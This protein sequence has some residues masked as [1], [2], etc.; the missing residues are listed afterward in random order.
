[1]IELETDR[2]SLRPVRAD[3]LQA[4]CEL[5]ADTRVMSSVGGT[6]SLEQCRAWLER[7]LA[8]WQDY[9]YGRYSVARGDQFVGLV[10]L[11]R[12]DFDRAMVPG[13]E[14]AWR[15]AFDEWG[16]GYATEAARAAIA[17]GFS[18][19]GL[20]EVIGVTSIDNARSRRVMVRLGMTHSPR[21]TFE[22]PLLPD[23]DPLRTHVLYRLRASVA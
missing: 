19:V 17:H 6:L 1:M 23:G 18:S 11:S 8:H 13:I 7:Q 14:I 5:S 3:D 20:H 16:H 21:E 22:H 2:L 12:T 10:G 9:G 4:V 15:L